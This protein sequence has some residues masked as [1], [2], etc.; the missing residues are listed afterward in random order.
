MKNKLYTTNL[1]KTLTLLYLYINVCILYLDL[2]NFYGILCNIRNYDYTYLNKILLKPIFLWM[3]TI[4][5]KVIITFVKL[6]N[7][8][9]GNIRYPSKNTV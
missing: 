3:I 2:F 6:P 5:N 9:N 8:K 4:K 1:L 7:E